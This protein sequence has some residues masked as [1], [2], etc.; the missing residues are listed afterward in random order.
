MA[1][2]KLAEL[3]VKHGVI[4]IDRK[5]YPKTKEYTDAEFQSV[6]DNNLN[7]FH[8]VNHADRTAFLKANGY[9]VTHEN[10]MA[11]LSAR[12]QE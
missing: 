11:D 3:E 2:K 7:D 12:P 4:A 10:M 6:L 5:K 9:E 1:V 8:P